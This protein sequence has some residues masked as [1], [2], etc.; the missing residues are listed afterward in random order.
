MS[1]SKNI[2]DLIRFQYPAYLNWRRKNERRFS[3]VARA[4][5]VKARAAKAEEASK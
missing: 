1:K 3:W 2:S 4:E 5:K